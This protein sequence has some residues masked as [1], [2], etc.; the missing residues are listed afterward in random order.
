M[1]SGTTTPGAND[2]GA[3]GPAMPPPPAPRAVTP[4][5][6]R[7]AWA[8][9]GVRLWWMT[10]LLVL[11]IATYVAAARGY[12]AWRQRQL[13][14]DGI[15][16][17]ARVERARNTQIRHVH[18]RDVPVPV[19]LAYELPDGRAHADTNNVDLTP[20]P[21][22]KVTVGDEL[23][24]RVD[25]DDPSRWVEDRPPM[26]WWR[27]LG[28]ALL[29]VPLAAALAGVA[30]LR[31]RGVLAT[32]QSGEPA[33]AV[34]VAHGQSALSPGSQALRLT[35]KDGADKRIFTLLHPRRAGILSPGDT[36]W[37]ISPPG[38]PHRSIEAA[39]YS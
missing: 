4:R 21:G 26:P 28:M 23:A 34:V 39:L 31:R 12:A 32:W 36:V 37:V 19:R 16:V 33:E 22:M 29:L 13:L 3:A 18:T 20:A 6:R 5:A 35:L 8:E 27:D 11:L 25:P 38:K 17:T 7:R 30:L 10:A 14:A 2:P 1:S 15:P 9:P 24:V